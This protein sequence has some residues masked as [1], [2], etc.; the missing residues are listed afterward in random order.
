VD[1]VGST[2]C[3]STAIAVGSV[4]DETGNI[5]GF[6]NR[7]ADL[8]LLAPGQPIYAAVPNNGY[9]SKQGT[10]MAAPHV[11]GAFAALKAHDNSLTADEMEAL[12][13]T[14]SVPKFDSGSGLTFPRLDL[15]QVAIHLFSGD[16]DGDVDVDIKDLL[17]LKNALTG[18][19]SLDPSQ[20]LRADVYPATGDGIL[21]MADLLILQTM[22]LAP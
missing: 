17:L 13:E 20:T 2:A 16:I 19:L 7:S 21:D 3:V 9:G 22:L 6:T 4:N 15:G 18:N 5:N 1:A 12:L 8:D 14:H 10:S 11:T